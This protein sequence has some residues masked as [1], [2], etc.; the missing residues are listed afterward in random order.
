MLVSYCLYI[1]PFH[2]EEGK[3]GMLFL[4]S[5]LTAAITVASV[6]LSVASL[7][8]GAGSLIRR[9]ERSAVSKQKLV[10]LFTAIFIFTAFLILGR[11]GVLHL[12]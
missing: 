6:V 12:K 8:V 11:L 4:L 2:D 5:L 1:T 7:F 9:E 10:I 3:N